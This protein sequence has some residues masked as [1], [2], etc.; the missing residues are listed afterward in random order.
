MASPQ[1]NASSAAWADA[2]PAV[3]LEI[4]QGGARSAALAMDGIDF[5]I[6]SV[7]GCDLRLAADGPGVICLFARH[8]AG[9]ALRKLAPTQRI[10]INDQPA[11]TANLSDG[12]CVRIGSVE[13]QVRISPAKPVA[14][15]PQ[16]TAGDA[17]GLE[18][19]WREREQLLQERADLIEHQKAELAKLRQEMGDVRRQL[20]DHYQD[21]RDRLAAVQEELAAARRDIDERSK[22]LQ[23]DEADA[24]DRRLRERQTA[25]EL[26][27][28]GRDMAARAQCF[29]EERRLF[30]ERQKQSADDWASRDADL[31]M[32]ENNLAEQLRACETKIKQHDA[33]VL[34]LHRLEG[35][36]DERQTQLAEQADALARQREQLNQDFAELT[37]QIA[38]LEELR[39]ATNETADRLAAQ[40]AEQDAVGRRLSERTAELE[41]QQAMLATL[42]GRLE[43]MRDQM[44]QREQE[45]DEQAARQEA[46]EAE[47]VRKHQ[48]AEQ[49]HAAL[50]ADRGQYESDRRQWHERSAVL[51]SAVRQLK[52]TQEKLGLEQERLRQEK[53]QVEQLRRQHADADAALQS[54]LA[55]IAQTRAD[56]DQERQAQQQRGIQLVEREQACQALQEQLH[57]RGEEIAGRHKEIGDKLQ[58]YQTKLS[59][60]EARHKSLEQ[61]EQELARQTE[62]WRDELAQKT[63]ALAKQHQAIAGVE[64]MHQ[65]QL[66]LLAVERKQHAD[67]RSR[68]QLEQEA[69]LEK[70]AQARAE[71]ET[72]RNDAHALSRD[73]PEAELR[74]G[75]AVDRLA[76]ARAQLRGHLDEIHQY[77]RSCQD[78]LEQLRARLQ[79]DLDKLRDEEQTLRRGQDEHRLA[80]AGFRQQ[81]ID[82]QGQIAEL[83]SVLARGETRLERKQAQVEEKARTIEAQSQQLVQ[84]AEQLHEQERDVADRREEIDRHLVDMREWYRHK[85]RDLAGM[86]LVPDTLRFDSNQRPEVRSQESGDGDQGAAEGTESG[87][88]VPD[89]EGIVPTGR[90]I[91][92]LAGAVDQGDQKLG[93]VLREAQLVDADALTALLAEAR[94]QRRTLR[95]VLLASGVVTL[96]QL[97]LIETGEV[98]RLM[99]GPVRIIDRLRN[100]VHETVY[101]VFD[102]RRGAEA[103]LRHLAEADLAD[104]I[105]P[106]EFRQRFGQARLNDPHLANTLEVLELAGRPAA[107]QEWLSGLPATDWPPLAAAPGVCHRLFTQAAQGLAAAHHAGMIH[108]HLADS[109]LLLTADGVLK[110]CGL[111]EPAW[112]IGI[113]HDD[114]PTPRDDLRTLG[115]IVSGWCTPSGVRKGAKTK[116]LPDALVSVLYRLAAEGDDGYRDVDEL[117]ADLEKTAAAIPPN[118]EAWD[119]LLRYVREH[120]TAEAILRQSA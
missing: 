8:P 56:L 46:R 76:G 108:G 34:R 15:P 119:R 7:P 9:V 37:Q 10:L 110:I 111:G 90:S 79:G 91:L 85:L 84:H 75:A 19:E 58:D 28:R 88:L 116:P 94:R 74:A 67:E 6:G 16:E 27:Q 65:E 71:L 117:L 11:S 4:R 98:R 60:V 89:E 41:G 38:R 81:L 29:E 68:F 78:E 42:R 87:A 18:R 83:K 115:R 63:D 113:Q 31:R 118:S 105:K 104:P 50:E 35:A 97:A 51:E 3:T 112:L 86:P 14:L 53:E 21:R 20:F 109:L 100:S 25:E 33:D 107:L 40:K 102:P 49:R 36:L 103:V 80:M 12:D 92:S 26:E 120:G 69:A 95:Q 106:D 13:I 32:R 96:Y 45:L 44:R 39:S 24:A 52:E 99:L 72:L 1:Q 114:E 64:A 30:D 17:T 62:T 48:E 70:I 57:R 93:Q 5:L 22:K 47:L 73:L 23:L 54:Q 77:V 43:R 59:A 55:Q 101:R 66:N 61:R 82:W 2:L